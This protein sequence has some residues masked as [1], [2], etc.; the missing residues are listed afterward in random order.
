[1]NVGDNIAVSGLTAAGKT[2]HAQL[3]AQ[4]LDY[5]YISATQ[6]ILDIAGIEARST[7]NVW[8]RSDSRVRDMLTSLEAARKLT[9][10]LTE[11]A[12]TRRRIVF[13][14]W[15]LAWAFN[16]P[17]IKVWIESDRLSRT[18][19]CYVSQGPRPQLSLTECRKVMDEKDLETRDT[20]RKEYG[21]DIFT[22]RT[23]F[24]AVLDNSWLISEPTRESADH[25]IARFDRTLRSVISHLS[26]SQVA[27]VAVGEESWNETHGYEG[28]VVRSLG[29]RH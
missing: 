25:G 24:D 3:L 1:M 9:S 7:D 8:F 4:W 10:T 22:D 27:D 2:T 26:G 15:G 13:D 5:E 11:L 17:L 16:G 23:V 12:A 29:Q 20:F 19:K 6:L 21:V 14:T 28:V 18:W